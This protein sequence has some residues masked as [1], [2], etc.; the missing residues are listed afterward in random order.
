MT[1]APPARELLFPDR[2]VRTDSLLY[3][4]K[5]RL[6]LPEPYTQNL[7]YARSDQY[8]TRFFIASDSGRNL[9]RMESFFL[10]I[11]GTIFE[12]SSLPD[13]AGGHTVVLKNSIRNIRKGEFYHPGFVRNLLDYT[14]ID[15]E[16]SI[17]YRVSIRSGQKKKGASGKFNFTVALGFNSVNVERKFSDLLDY[18]IRAMRREAGYSLRKARINRV[19]DNLLSNPFNLINFIRVPSERDIII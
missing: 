16:A 12:D 3:R 8:Q 14:S 17:S 18:E 19:G 15:R 1:D 13:N 9:E 6:L 11:Y 4:E 10:R 7:F 5:C 2:E